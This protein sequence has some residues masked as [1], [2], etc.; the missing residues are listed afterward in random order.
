MNFK[1]SRLNQREIDVRNQ[2]FWDEVCGTLMGQ[3]LGI[4]TES[5]VRDLHLLDVAYL[6]YYPYLLEY[7]REVLAAETQG[8]KVLEVGPGYGTLGQLLLDMKADY[9]CVDIAMN[10]TK[11]MKTRYQAIGLEPGGRV[12]VASA[13]NLPYPDSAFDF[14]FAIGVLQHTGNLSRG[15]DEVFRVTRPGGVVV[16]MVYNTLSIKRLVS[17]VKYAFSKRRARD[18]GTYLRAAYDQDS[19]GHAAPYTD[20]V[21]RKG[22]RSLLN[23]YGKVEI[24]GRNLDSIQLNYKQHS[25]FIDRSRLPTILERLF[26]HDLYARVRK[27]V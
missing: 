14:V 9:Y 18:F 21:S 4:L 12:A 7:V 27:S 3:S 20:F 6:S 17:A 11:I 22:L 10:P 23:P 5:G 1:Q 25:W 2:D 13:L 16:L 26:G 8:K 19:K 15:I 24:V